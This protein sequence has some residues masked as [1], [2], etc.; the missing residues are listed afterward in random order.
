MVEINNKAEYSVDIERL[1][2]TA[3]K[4]LQHFQK[5]DRDISLALV[6]DEEI[7]ELNRVYRGLDKPTDVLAFPE[8][9]EEGSLG[10]IIIDYDQVAR[11]APK[12]SQTPEEELVFILVHGLLHLLGYSDYTEED[13]NNMIQLGR[14][15]IKE[16]DL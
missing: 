3:E 14:D 12:F 2:R 6:G 7:R 10:E 16:L 8:E 5:Q 4:F 15:L 13:K 11:Q 1:R 9:E